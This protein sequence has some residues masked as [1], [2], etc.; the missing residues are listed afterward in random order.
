MNHSIRLLFSVSFALVMGGCMPQGLLITLVSSNKKLVETE[1]LR[2]S[3]LATDTI[4]IIDVDGL[5][6]NAY[7]SKFFGQG[8]HPVSLLTEELDKAS[9]DKKVKAVILRI[10]SPG[11]GVTASDLMYQEI[12]HFK[13][14]TSKPIAAVMMDVAASGGYYIACGCDE[15]VAQRTTVTGSIGVI[16]QLF[17][18]TGT[19]KIIGLSSEAITSGPHKDSGSPLRK[20]TG[21]ERELFQAIVNDMYQ[22]FVEVVANGRPKL[23]ENDVRKLADGRVYTAPQALEA[24]LID[25]I[26]TLRQTIAELKEKIGAKKIRVVTYHR[27]LDY[28]PN[29]YSRSPVPTPAN[30]NLLNLNLVGGAQPTLMTNSGPRFMYLWSP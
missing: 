17:D 21:E 13:E 14:S 30:V 19:M 15:I 28:R 4:A 18:A 20:M 1:L 16:M 22:R 3:I 2:E 6:L 7:T 25:R 12:Q 8:E 26:A 29:Y 24:G 9:R 5:I 10:N 23:D 27:P 11:G